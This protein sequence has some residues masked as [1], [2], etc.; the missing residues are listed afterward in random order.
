M[1]VRKDDDG[2]VD[3][4]VGDGDVLQQSAMLEG[5]SCPRSGKPNERPT[6]GGTA[7]AESVSA[8]L[9]GEYVAFAAFAAYGGALGTLGTYGGG[10]FGVLG[11]YVAA[12]GAQ[13]AYGAYGA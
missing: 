7:E 6:P 8:G 2:G 5:T 11:V 4:D 9:A 12:F 1:L 13:G 10:A 3:D